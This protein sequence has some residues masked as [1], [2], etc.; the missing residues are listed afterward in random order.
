M[1]KKRRS[2]EEHLV[3]EK[4]IEGKSSSLKCPSKILCADGSR[5][6]GDETRTTS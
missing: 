2:E 5:M 1:K 6:G 3:S 4:F